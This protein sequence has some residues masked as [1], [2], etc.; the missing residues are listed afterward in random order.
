MSKR[1]E[2]QGSPRY[3][4]RAVGPDRE[5]DKYWAPRPG[6]VIECHHYGTDVNDARELRDWLDR[7]IAWAEEWKC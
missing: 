4:A 5:N 2:A 7:F 6:A 3:F 1:P